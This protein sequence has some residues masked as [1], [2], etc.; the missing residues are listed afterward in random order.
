MMVVSNKDVPFDPYGVVFD[1]RAPGKIGIGGIP[2][3]HVS[4]M[5]LVGFTFDPKLTRKP[6]IDAI[7]KKARIRL[8]ALRR[9]RPL[10][11]DENMKTMYIMFV[12]SIMEYGGVQFQGARDTHLAKLDRIQASAMKLGNFEIESLKQRRDA[13]TA[14]LIFKLLDGRGRGELNSFA[15][16]IVVVSQGRYPSKRDHQKVGIRLKDPTT[17]YSLD[18]Y[19][20][21][22]AGVAALIFDQ[23][24]QA[25]LQEGK[26][27]G[28]HKIEK[29]ATDLLIGK[30]PK[31]SQNIT[32]VHSPSNQP[33][34]V[35]SKARVKFQKPKSTPNLWEQISH[36]TIQ[37]KQKEIDKAMKQLHN[38][39]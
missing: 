5:K 26:S 21:S 22:I 30:A 36:F 4:S 32:P 24:P 23:L 1:E 38:S 15:P 6:M 25:L 20:K 9:L 7:A 3:K 29:R 17:T 27:R 2:V 35:P 18:S 39:L 12:R 28:W 8:G 16:E 19:T 10:L 33:P 37:G 34:D 13:A 14:S 11:S 31:A